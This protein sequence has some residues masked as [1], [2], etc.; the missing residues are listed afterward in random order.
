MTSSASDS[1]AERWQGQRK[2]H[3]NVPVGARSGQ[4]GGNADINSASGG[5]RIAL[6]TRNLPRAPTALEKELEQ[7]AM[8]SIMKKAGFDGKSP[9]DLTEEDTLATEAESDHDGNEA[10][11]DD[12]RY[13]EDTPPTTLEPQDSAHLQHPPVTEAERTATGLLHQQHQQQQHPLPTP[14]HPQPQPTTSPSPI[15][16][17]NPNPPPSEDPT[18]QT[19]PRPNQASNDPHHPTS[20]DWNALRKGVRNARG[21]ICYY[22]ASFVEDPWATLMA[23]R[24]MRD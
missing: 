15:H 10:E 23:A 1:V 19:P 16:N 13:V 2:R 5:N 3:L 20:H 24:G 17:P 6:G 21:D 18:L 8:A 12:P 7:K 4:A 22:D 9:L 11:D 14:T